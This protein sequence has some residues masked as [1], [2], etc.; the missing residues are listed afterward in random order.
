VTEGTRDIWHKA[1]RGWIALIAAWAV[2]I[3][4]ISPTAAFA[5]PT[6]PDDLCLSAPVDPAAG[7]LPGSAPV[8]HDHPC[9]LSGGPAVAGVPP[10]GPAEAG[11]IVD[12]VA[13]GVSQ[14]FRL[15]ARPASPECHPQAPRA[16][17]TS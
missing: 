3:A 14:P 9:C 7:G 6:V 16:P 1:F 2:F 5:H 12:T 8:D 13:V 11:P 4:A 10:Q 17:P 15:P